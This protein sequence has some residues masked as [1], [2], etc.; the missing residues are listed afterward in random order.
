MPHLRSLRNRLAVVF[1]LI[2]L[3]AIAT[4]YLTTVPRLQDRLTQQKLQQLAEDAQRASDGGVLAYDLSP[5]ISD[6]TLN[7]Q[8]NA[9]ASRSSAEVL[10][11]KPL[12]NPTGLSLASDSSVNSGVRGGEVSPLAIEAYESR[13]PHTA[14]LNTTAG[15]QAIAAQP[16]FDDKKKL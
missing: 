11:M 16:L 3:G 14:T 2:V 1:G 10:V 8:V 4:V 15:R 5:G 9:I 12:T 13:R 6:K 7:R